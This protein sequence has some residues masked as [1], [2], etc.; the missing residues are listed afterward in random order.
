MPFGIPRSLSWSPE[1][2]AQALARDGGPDSRHGLAH[3]G[4][5]IFITYYFALKNNI[6]IYIYI[7]VYAVVRIYFI[8]SI[9]YPL[10]S[11]ERFRGFEGF[12]GPWG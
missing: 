5:S 9:L 2:R 7:I 12:G 8:P 1:P 3:L 6:Y 10:L 11:R 4:E